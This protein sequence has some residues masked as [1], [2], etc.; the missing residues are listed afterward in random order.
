MP[1]ASSTS[2]GTVQPHSRID[3]AIWSTCSGL[4]VRALRAY[5]ISAATARRSNLSA[6][7][8]GCKICS[9]GVCGCAALTPAAPPRRAR[10]GLVTSRR[11]AQSHTDHFYRSVNKMSVP[12]EAEVRDFG[13]KKQDIGDGEYERNDFDGN[14]GACSAFIC[15]G[16]GTQAHGGI[17]W[18]L[19]VQQLPPQSIG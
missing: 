15:V 3:A 7:H 8:S 14:F 1:P 6:G 18:A 4:C 19:A 17:C 16:S 10:T 12:T 11:V 9:P 5:G 13:V 2:T